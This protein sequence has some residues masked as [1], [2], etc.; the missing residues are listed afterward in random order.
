MYIL[1][2]GGESCAHRAAGVQSIDIV[3]YLARR[4]RLRIAR[5][6]H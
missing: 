4:G 2:D 1:G 6:V 5:I 3:E